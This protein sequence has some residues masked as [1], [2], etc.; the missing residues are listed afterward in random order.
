MKRITFGMLLVGL[1]VTGGCSTLAPEKQI[2]KPIDVGYSVT[3][4]E[5]SRSIGHVLSAPVVDGNNVIELLNGDQI[6]PAMIAAITNAKK[7]ITLEMYIWS[8]GEVSRLFINALTERARAGVKVHLLVDATGS[9]KLKRAD[10]EELR[11]AGAEVVSYNSFHLLRPFGLNHRTHR[12]MMVVDGR[13]G[14]AGGVC[15]S[16]DWSGNAE[17][18]HWRDTHFAIEGPVV[19]QIQGVF[20][21]NWLQ[22]QSEVLHGEDYFP[23]LDSSGSMPAQFFRSGP[24]DA[25]EHAR[26]SYLMAIGAARTNIRLAHVYFAPSKVVLEALLEARKRGVEIEVIVPGKVDNFVVDKA[27]RSRWGQLLKAGVKFY[28]YQPTLFHCKI[29]VVDDSWITAGS[30]NFDERS[31]RVNDEA[32]LNVWSRELAAKLIQTFEKDKT[33]CRELSENNFKRRNWCGRAFEQFFGLFRSQL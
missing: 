21:E 15:L 7:S 9:S 13:I 19:A 22:A 11:E 14:F 2:D 16:D 24:R 5:F 10:R 1:L 4:E 18:G 28:E 23:K 31:F 29:M 32:N 6:F 25:A 27:S 12:K 26:L 30:V 20:M 33:Q 8:S 3:D 17:P